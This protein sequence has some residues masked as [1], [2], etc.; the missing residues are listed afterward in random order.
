MGWLVL[1]FGWSHLFGTPILS[2]VGHYR[3]LKALEYVSLIL[4]IMSYNFSSTLYSIVSSLWHYFYH[5]IKKRM[6]AEENENSFALNDQSRQRNRRALRTI[7]GL[8]LLFTVTILPVRG[9]MVVGGILKVYALN[10]PPLYS[11][12]F[13][14]LRWPWLQLF[15]T[16]TT[17]SIFSFTQKWFLVFESFCWQ[18]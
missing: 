14:W 6:N 11:M 13:I 10:K 4:K 12:F 2:W 9:F 5:K 18:F 1:W 15:S 3:E 8:I 7:R 17:C 16:W